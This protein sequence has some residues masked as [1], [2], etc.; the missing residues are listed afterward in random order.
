MDI[1]HATIIRDQ[2]PARVYTALT[3]PREL[4]IW[5]DAPTLGQSEVGKLLEFQYDQGRRTLKMEIIQLEPAQQ[6]QWRVVQAM[7]K[8]EAQEQFITWTLSPYEISTLI[9]FRMNGWPDEDESYPSVSYKWA[10]FMMRLRIHLG[11]RRD[12]ATLNL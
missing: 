10:S 9:D 11:D 12:I 6:V 3:Q 7:W 2:P 4:E 1:H 5:M 8:S